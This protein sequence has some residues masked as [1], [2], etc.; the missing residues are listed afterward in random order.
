MPTSKTLIEYDYGTVINVNENGS[1]VEY[2]LISKDSNSC[3]LLRVNAVVAKRMHS[4][5]VS[6]YTDCEMDQYLSSDSA[7]GF[8]ERFDSNTKSA[9]VMRSISTYSYGDTECHYISRKCYLPSYGQCF[10]GTPTAT[11]PD[12][13]IV[14][15]L[16]IWKGTLDGNSARIAKDNVGASAVYWWLRSP[17]SATA[18][19]G[20]GSSG[21]T[22]S[23]GATGSGNW[24]RPVLSVASATIASDD[25][26]GVIQLLPVATHREVAFEGLAGTSSQKP[27]KALVRYA[28][29]GLTN[30]S[31][32][33]CNNYG[34]DNPVWEDATAGTVVTFSNETKQTPLWQVGI[35]CYGDTDGWSTGYFEE[36][37][38]LV[39]V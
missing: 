33:V 39:E 12:T 24:C 9:L 2:V 3:E 7:G 22:N 28:A 19:W 8:L 23:N 29:H 26:T 15:E 31:V 37:T 21:N 5:N 11:E 34:D 17:Y 32:Q 14:P 18:F 25:G 35:K 27:R 6:N 1:P 10:L 13:T 30:L 4:S 16:M 20:V 38:V 36:P